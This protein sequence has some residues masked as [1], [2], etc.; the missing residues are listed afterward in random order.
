M[1]LRHWMLIFSESFSSGDTLSSVGNL[2]INI[3]R[4]QDLW[5]IDVHLR[6]FRGQGLSDESKNT[7][8]LFP[9]YLADVSDLTA[10]TLTFMV[11][12][13]AFHVLEMRESRGFLDPIL[14]QAFTF[15]LSDAQANPDS[16]CSHGWPW[17]L[18]FLISLSPVLSLYCARHWTQGFVHFR[19]ASENPVLD[20]LARSIVFFFF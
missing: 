9:L 6:C 18:G 7:E 3:T 4:S 19:Q 15:L 5:I 20:E 13:V 12:D 8:F 17:P 16:L 10:Y 1:E 11:T 2:S 14:L